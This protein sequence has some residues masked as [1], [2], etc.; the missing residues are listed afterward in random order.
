MSTFR[1][2]PGLSPLEE[3]AWKGFNTEDEQL[4][5]WFNNKLIPTRPQLTPAEEQEWDALD[6]LATQWDTNQQLAA[7]SAPVVASSVPAAAS[8]ASDEESTDKGDG[9]EETKGDK[10]VELL[11]N[12]QETPKIEDAVKALRDKLVSVNRKVTL[13][14]LPGD[15]TKYAQ[16]PNVDTFVIYFFASSTRFDFGDV[17]GFL[18]QGVP[19]MISR[20]CGRIEAHLVDCRHSARS[21]EGHRCC[22]Q[23]RG[24]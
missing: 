23:S 22:H 9:A 20:V 4:E 21:E 10:T 3:K 15:I 6:A 17:R 1:L 12:P 5:W 14:A 11:Y 2:P 8:S 19:G 13:K 16:T 7:S 24:S 18:E